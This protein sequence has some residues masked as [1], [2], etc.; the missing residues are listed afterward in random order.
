[1][2]D[3]NLEKSQTLRIIIFCIA[4]G[5]F[6]VGVVLSFLDKIGGVAGAYTTAIICLIFVFLSEF[7][8]FKGFG[9]EA[10][11]RKK[12]QEAD[13]IIRHLRE[14][15]LPIAELLFA[16]DARIGR[17]SGPIPRPDR[18]RIMKQIEDALNKIGVSHKGMQEAK[19][20]FDRINIIDL[21]SPIFKGAIKL[22]D[23]KLH[24][25][26]N[27]F[28]KIFPPP[29]TITPEYTNMAE[30]LKKLAKTKEDLLSWAKFGDCYKFASSIEQ[31][32]EECDQ[33]TDGE[34]RELLTTYH[35][36]IE[37]LKYYAENR[38][39]RRLEAYFQ[40]DD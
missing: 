20:E 1:M 39:F 28:N 25:K 38:E 34:K 27:K 17:C 23:H 9:I 22:L 11:L 8:R 12:I 2:E 5:L 40:K 16:V 6:V 4:I 37:D 13:E 3:K 35:E 29:I 24:E 31:F 26:Q 14:V 36:D 19:S 32:I 7:E 21:A 30:D 33:V 18:Y 15:S 10:E